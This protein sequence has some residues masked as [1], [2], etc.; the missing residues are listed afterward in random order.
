[1]FEETTEEGMMP[2]GR[3]SRVYIQVAIRKPMCNSVVYPYHK[4]KWEL[5]KAKLYIN[6]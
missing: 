5:A 6:R 3:L 4:C 2:F 1:M